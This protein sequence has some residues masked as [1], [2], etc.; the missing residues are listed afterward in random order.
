MVSMTSWLR[1]V[2]GGHR[3]LSLFFGV[4]S[5]VFKGDRKDVKQKDVGVEE[6]KYR[7]RAKAV[8]C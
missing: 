8:E 3:G 7:G 4:Y 5:R 6:D 2:Q 1:R